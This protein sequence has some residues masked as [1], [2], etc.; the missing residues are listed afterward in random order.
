MPVTGIE[1]WRQWSEQYALLPFVSASHRT[2]K[3]PSWEPVWQS[4]ATDCAFVL[5]SGK[6][7]RYTYLGLQPV[8]RIVGDIEGATVYAD[9]GQADERTRHV[10]WQGKP[11]TLLKRWMAPFRVPDW[12]SGFAGDGEDD[13]DSGVDGAMFAGGCVGYLAYDV[14]RSLERFDSVAVDDGGLPLY[15]FA[16]YDRLWVFDHEQQHLL[17]ILHVDISG[18][19][20]TQDGMLELLYEKAAETVA[21][22]HIQWERW[23]QAGLSAAARRQ[24]QFAK[25]QVADL[26]SLHEMQADIKPS[27]TKEQFSA[28]V[29][30]VQEYIRSGDVFQVNL[31]VRQER[32]LHTDPTD[33]YEWLR[34]L[35]PSPYMGLLKFP[36]YQLVCGSPELLVKLHDGVLQTRPIAGTRPRGADGDLDEQLAVELILNEK[37]RAEH[38]ML[39][40]LERN[41][42]GRVSRFGT[43]KVTDLMTI[44]KYSHVM[45]IVS[46]VEGQLRDDLD[47]YD[48]L[49]AAFPGGTITGAPKVRTMEIIEELEPV[50]RGPYTGS[51]GWIDYNGNLE[52]NIIIRTLVAQR[53][54]AYVQA[55]AGIVIDSVPEKEYV[56]SLN[57]AKALWAAVRLS[58]TMS[59]GVEQR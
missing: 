9:E 13:G 53:G 19:D 12:Q 59:M 43:V 40:D 11:L 47:G 49:A 21:G 5:E 6:A 22:M 27:L 50:R 2:V 33:V 4:A 17:C 7:G 29:N 57:K 26:N 39:V 3:M 16:R 42:L 46:Q 20:V 32:S 30:A 55:G 18:V 56:E 1:T 8:S 34:L 51:L 36:D 24:Q 23:L 31:S 41:D 48:A 37:E 28:A 25:V 10:I 58:E 54:K 15:A 14:A 45:H 52:F 44:E 35:N 38:I